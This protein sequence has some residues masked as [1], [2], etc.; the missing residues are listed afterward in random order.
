MKNKSMRVAVLLLALVM[1]TSCFVGG[2][3][4]KYTSKATA[5]S[6]ARVAYWGF[7]ST[8]T[9]ELG[10]FDFTDTGILDGEENLIAPG[11]G[12]EIEL[13]I[14]PAV[15]DLNKAPEVAYKVQIDT[16]NS[17]SPTYDTYGGTD[18]RIEWYITVGEETTKYTSWSAFTKG[19]AAL[20]GST[21]G[22]ATYAAGEK[23]PILYGGNDTIKIGWKW[24][25]E[26]YDTESPY[27]LLTEN[28]ETDTLTGNKALTS[29]GKVDLKINVTVTQ[30][31]S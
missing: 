25:F 4:A 31:N 15:A 10:L 7:D 6:Q 20:D 9:V 16:N 19:I 22:A 5:S 21:S 1:I 23:A 24:V 11:S 30:V 28:D 17:V 13:K 12:N 26:K 3:F 14:A 27:M 8:E 2:T 29:Y 18:G